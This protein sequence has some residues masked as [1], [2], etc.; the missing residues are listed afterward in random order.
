[1]KGAKVQRSGVGEGHHT[2]VGA[3]LMG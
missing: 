2:P 3:M 1:M